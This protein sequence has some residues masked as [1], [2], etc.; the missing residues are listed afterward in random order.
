M[1][2]SLGYFPFWDLPSPIVKVGASPVSD[3]ECVGMCLGLPFLQSNL[4]KKN[5]V[6]HAV[7]HIA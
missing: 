4:K 1:I 5:N 7:G 3:P 2:I 6:G